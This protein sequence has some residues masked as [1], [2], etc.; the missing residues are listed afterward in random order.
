MK[1]STEIDEIKKRIKPRIDDH[2]NY[3]MIGVE[4]VKESKE[5]HVT[6]CF[7]GGGDGHPS[8]IALDDPG[9]LNP[10]PFQ[11]VGETLP[12]AIAN[13]KKALDNAEQKDYCF[14]RW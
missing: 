12:K 10:G 2:V 4:F 13:I 3:L 1:I 11:G 8:Y 6:P 7:E 9:I 5:W 14:Y